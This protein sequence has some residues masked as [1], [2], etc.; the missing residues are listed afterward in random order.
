[1]VG[2]WSEKMKKTW[3][4]SLNQLSHV[5]NLIYP[6]ALFQQYH[7]SQP[8]Q[9]HYHH[10]PTDWTF[11]FCIQQANHVMKAHPVH[12]FAT[13]QLSRIIIW[14]PFV[15]LFKL[16]GMELTTLAIAGTSTVSLRA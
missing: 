8:S 2:G 14:F 6:K 11:N 16:S 5:R 12:S 9:R 13:F 7:L 3:L 1:M 4:G 10:S 15:V